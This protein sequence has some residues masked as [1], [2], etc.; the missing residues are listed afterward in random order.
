[1]SSLRILIEIE[2]LFL[3]DLC[4]ADWTG[5]SYRGVDRP[6]WPVQKDEGGHGTRTGY[7]LHPYMPE[8]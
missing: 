6:S 7:W 4:T 5:S 3:K 2:D 8:L 1:M